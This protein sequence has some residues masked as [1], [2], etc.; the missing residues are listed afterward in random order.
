MH[1]IFVNRNMKNCNGVLI[2]SKNTE[3]NMINKFYKDIRS[4][5]EAQL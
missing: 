5:S 3:K 2:M 1:K 4:I